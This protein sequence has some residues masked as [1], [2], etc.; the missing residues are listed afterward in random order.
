MSATAGPADAFS[1]RGPGAGSLVTQG[2][3]QQDYSVVQTFILLS[4]FIYILANLA[5]DLVAAAIDPRIGRGSA[6]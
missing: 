4:A 3:L 5:I 1:G 2:L 6:P